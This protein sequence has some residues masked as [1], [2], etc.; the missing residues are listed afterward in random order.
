[1]DIPIAGGEINREIFEFKAFLDQE[2]Y[3]ILQPNCTMAEG[4]SRCARIAA[5]LK[6]TTNSAF[7]MPGCRRPGFYANLQV[8]CRVRPATVPGSNLPLTPPY[9]TPE[10]SFHHYGSPN[11][12]FEG[13]VPLPEN[14]DWG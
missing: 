6:S 12:R 10:N 7:P 11:D 1:V 14:R 8:A 4:C 9:W 5:L 13:Y 2:C 3:D